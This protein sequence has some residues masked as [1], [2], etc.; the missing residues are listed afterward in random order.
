MGWKYNVGQIIGIVVGVTVG[1]GAVNY[2]IYSIKGKPQV[3]QYDPNV[4]NPPPQQNM[5]VYDEVVANVRAPP[6]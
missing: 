3:E 1:M 6:R 4:Y 2:A 5:G